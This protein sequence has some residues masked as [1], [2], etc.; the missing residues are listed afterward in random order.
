MSFVRFFARLRALFRGGKLDAEMSEEM[1]AH[2]ELQAAENERRGMDA[3]EAR[4]AAQRSFGG[5]E[6]LKERVRDQR[7]GRWLADLRQDV[8]FGLRAL[9]RE[10]GFTA[11]CILVVALGIG[12]NT[13]IFS[14][15]DA[16]VLRPLPVPEPARVMR[17]WETN[18]ARHI[19]SFSVSFQNFGDWARLSQSWAML[20]AVDQRNVNLLNDGE[21]ERLRA[22]IVTS[23]AF[24]LFGMRIAHGRGFGP[25]DDLPGRGDVAVLA[26]ALWRRRFGADDRVIGRAIVVDGKPRTVIGVLAPARGLADGQEI[27]LPLPPF[28]PPDRDDRDFEVYGRLKPGVTQAQAQEEMAAVAREI[29]RQHPDVNAGWSVRLEPLFDVVVGRNVRTALGLTFGAVGVLLAIA[30]ANFSSLLAVRAARRGRELA[31]RAALG[32]GRARLVRQLTTESLLLALMGGVAGVLLASWSVDFVRSLELA[33]V[34]RTV[35]VALDRR[36]LAF[37]TVATILTGIAAG[38]LPAWAASRVDVQE[39]LKQSGGTAGPH[40]PRLRNALVVGQLALSIVLLAVAGML[41]RAF[42]RLQSTDLGFRPDRIV[43]AR[44]GPLNNGRALV[45]DLLERVGGLPGVVASGAIS[46][47]PMSGYNTSNHV[48]PVGAAAI[49]TA[50]SIQSEWRIVTA[51]YFRTMQIPV[52]RGRAFTRADNGTAG[53]VVI[54]SETLARLLWGQEDPIGRQINPGGGTTF[55]TVVGVVGDVRSRDPAQGPQPAYYLSAHRAVWGTMTLAVRTGGDPTT[56]VPQLRAELR[57]LDAALPLFDVRTMDDMIGRQLA[58][59][60]TV[61]ILLGAFAL[62]ALTLAVAG[63]Y[64]VMAH[65]TGQRTREVGI[66]MALGAQ[67]ADVIRPLLTHGARLIAAGCISGL[68]LALAA[69]ALLRGRFEAVGAA[70]PW[71]LGGSALLLALVSLLACY[72][73]AR[74]ASRLDPLVALRTE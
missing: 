51:D 48:Y 9:V 66:R 21:P 37:A 44:I 29:E 25:E 43:T 28:A 10:P 15:V 52:R 70:D 17:V 73:P 55:S 19:T 53:R 60:R 54:V 49:P 26:D 42:D 74:R 32:G 46:S 18:A 56:I 13:A 1:R 47:A 62:L 72:L 57:T 31:I 27:F 59:Q 14:V 6:Q 20:A 39:G 33:G 30:C 8:H 71:A 69:V 41:L 50:K 2:L 11:I 58:P 3:A 68:G 45:E 64:G 63:L 22:Q 12:A 16:V 35:E 40:R 23:M 61:T 65:A 24:A 34:P 36:V 4:Y 67:R 7:G 38:F 5:V